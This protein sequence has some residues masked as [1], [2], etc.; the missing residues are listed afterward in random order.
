[1]LK[2]LL[3][4]LAG[5][6][7][8]TA[9]ARAAVTIPDCGAEAQRTC[10]WTDQEY[11]DMGV[12]SCEF[13]LKAS[14]SVCINERRRIWNGR[15]AWEDWAVK[16][17]RYGISVNEPIN[18]VPTI[19]A[20]NAFSSTNQ[21]FGG[22]QSNQTYSITDQLRM[23]AR[24]LE[25]DPHWSAGNLLVCHNGIDPCLPA[26]TRP[27]ANVFIEIRN[28]LD[29]NPGE[30]I[31]V[32][33]D[34]HIAGQNAQLTSLISTYFADKAYKRAADPGAWP[35]IAQV[36]AA[37]KQVLFGSR[38]NFISDGSWIWNFT[39]TYAT[40]SDHPQDY[41][42][43][44][45]T[46]G[47][48]NKTI[49]RAKTRWSVVAEGRS[50]SNWGDQT[51]LINDSTEVAKYLQCGVGVLALDYLEALGDP[52][53]PEFRRI[54]EDK[55][56]AA[57]IWS[58]D[59]GDYGTEGPAVL[60]G[61]TGRWQSR[62][63]TE[64][65]AFA[66]QLSTATFSDRKFVV[67]SAKGPWNRGQDLCSA[68]FPG[69][70]FSVPTLPQFNETVRAAAAV[71]S[72]DV[73]LNYSVVAT[74]DPS[75]SPTALQFS[76]RLGTVPAAAQEA[77]ILGRTGRKLVAKSNADWVLVGLPDGS[78]ALDAGNRVRISIAPSA[79][80]FAAGD[81]TT[82]VAIGYR[83]QGQSN[84]IRVDYKV[85]AVGVATL[86]LTPPTVRQPDTVT[87]TVT[88]NAGSSP[89]AISGGVVQLQE[90]IPP[91]TT[92]GT[93]TVVTRGTQA[94]TTSG[95]SVQV[96]ITLNSLQLS[97]GTHQLF[98]SYSGGSNFLPFDS[99]TR[100][101]VVQPRI[102]TSPTTMQFVMPQ[103][104]PLPGG[105]LLKVAPTGSSLQVAKFPTWAGGTPQGSDFLIAIDSSALAF[106][107]GAYLGSFIVADGAPGEATV[108]LNLI[109]QSPLEL[110][111]RSRT[112]T[113]ST[114]PVTTSFNVL[115]TDGRP[116]TVQGSASWLSASLSQN[117]APA[118]VLVSANPAGLAPGTYT[119]KV[120]VRSPWAA[121]SAAFT[122]TFNVTAP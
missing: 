16:Q 50:F 73:W 7:I 5:L 37:G 47:D 30:V 118:T 117:V 12:R 27:L 107:T 114:D 20:H 116:L 92:G 57:S 95:S 23:G 75:V 101:L 103:G 76:S 42:L 17:Q 39:S 22:D 64:Q 49:T 48:G 111:R 89:L 70:V 28:W 21:G 121:K 59:V 62:N 79:G 68:E 94:V 26:Y 10:P 100:P 14:S 72:T 63:Q 41:N 32:K 4:A 3:A 67:T 120:T 91:A 90:L 69:S 113:A 87:A 34:D 98:A 38:N 104:G 40:G 105:Q 65:H 29:D 93:P 54:F 109:V 44:T 51:G 8:S 82:T 1:M 77:L 80:S 60:L 19:G 24:F 43:D 110:S 11:W 13:D 55:R 56:I 88:L 84:S 66:C 96:P 33:L 25:I 102:V 18:F 6:L 45:C 58:F 31:F 35:T 99:V 83:G 52:V 9:P 78:T 2:P 112:L 108:P 115:N 81:Y 106:G 74:T 97:Q 15:D 53:I 122:V 119:G 61:S 46:D 86:T 85:Q 36:R 71:L